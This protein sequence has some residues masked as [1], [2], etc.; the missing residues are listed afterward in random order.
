MRRLL[1]KVLG[2][3]RPDGRVEVGDILREAL[4]VGRG[5]GG[6]GR[7]RRSGRRRVLLVCGMRLLARYGILGAGCTAGL[8]GGRVAGRLGELANY[9]R[10]A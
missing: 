8:C 7:A 6:D 9:L 5:K 1:A 2:E 3:G 4:R 10:R